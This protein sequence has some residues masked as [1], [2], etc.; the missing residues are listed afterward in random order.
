MLDKKM[1]QSTL[2]EIKELREEL[3]EA[4]KLAA[5]D[6]P[7]YASLINLKHYM[8]LRSENRTKIQEK[9]FLMSLSSLG[10][11]FAHVA[12][13]VDTIYDQL[14]S[15]LGL[16]MISAKET[17]AFHHI[18]IPES[19]ELASKNATALFGGKASAKLSKQSTAIMVTLPSHAAHDDGALIR[20][21]A[22]AGVNL[23]RI[24]TAHD[25]PE[26]WQGMADVIGDINRSLPEQ[27]QIR[28]FVDLAGP[29][30]RTGAICRLELD[31]VIGSN[32]G[33]K[34]VL[35]WPEGHKTLP[36]RNDPVTREKLPAQISIDNTLFGRLVPHSTI[37]ITDTNGKKAHLHILEKQGGYFR[38]MID[39]KVYLGD[40]TVLRYGDIS[41]IVLDRERQTDPIRLFAGDT[42]VIT[43][44]DIEGCSAQHDGTGTTLHPARIS[45]TLKGVASLVKVGDRI[46]IDD[47]KIGLEV[48]ALSTGEITCRVV[49]AKANGTLL[50]GEKG[51]NFPDT[52]IDTDAITPHD[53]KNLESVIGFADSLG[54]SFCQSPADVAN[55]QQIL[56]SRGRGD[57][58]IIA[59][60][61]TAQALK[62]IPQIIEQL[63]LSRKSGVMIARGDLAIEVGFS[64]LASIQEKL[65][66][67]CDAAHMPVIW[68]TQVLESQMKSNLPSRAE[69]T[70]AAMSG[71]AEC[72]MLNK[73][74]FA[75]DTIDVLRTILHDMH[76]MFKKNRQ[77]LGKETLWEKG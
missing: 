34:E 62:N 25:G 8:I 68:A 66:D 13:S 27:E 10:R 69:V 28:I 58:G 71:R 17:E 3:L 5:P 32:K 56:E 74:V 18:T 60:I 63:L 38:A 47:G 4:R 12:A 57:I 67:I 73:G 33:H 37:R 59:K 40:D 75:V 19:I 72:V 36:R 6:H 22:G 9:L 1:M 26:I 51:I 23:F 21:L 16:K 42:L 14:S 43:E 11:S 77:L 44:E 65:L 76:R 54:I 39:K 41:G 46:S 31:T 64:A 48:T 29:K 61:E 35:I 24:N 52:H 20:S 49:G 2:K 70:D 55:L 50:K 15:S 7:R 30:I 53:L 45:C